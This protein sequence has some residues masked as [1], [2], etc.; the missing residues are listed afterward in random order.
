MQVQKLQ[1]N[2]NLPSP[3]VIAPRLF[4]DERGY[5]FESFNEKE[6][7]E[8][9]LDVKFVQDNQSKSAYGVLRGMHFQKPP[10]EQAKLVR[11]VKG[12][13]YDIIIDIRRES[14][15]FGCF[16]GQYLSDKNF[17]Q[18]FVP[19][20]FAHGFITLEDD[21]IFQYKCDNYYNKESEGSI[22]ALDPAMNLPW[23]K[24][25]D[26]GDIILSEKD[27]VAPKFNEVFKVEN[28]DF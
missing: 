5:F 10:Y 22:N 23:D 15:Y 11:V 25:V 14:P 7:A 9:V 6:F 18:F 13:V 1:N 21:T 26:M 19:R 17:R 28:A 4:K 27:G 24:F 2:V 12:A 3:V 16:Y 20:G 8:K